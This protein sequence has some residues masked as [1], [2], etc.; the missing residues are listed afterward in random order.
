MPFPILRTPLVVLSESISLLEPNEIVTASFCSSNVTRLLKR[1]FQQKKL[2]EWRLFMTD[3]DSCGT[4]DIE[5][6]K[7]GKKINVISAKHISLLEGQTFMFSSKDP[8]LYFEDLRLGTT[9]IVN[10]VSDLFNLDVFNIVID[11]NGIWAIDWINNRQ[12]KMLGSIV[13]KYLL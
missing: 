6:S 13:Y 8:V 5:T 9:M 11:R 12:E 3:C 4:V 10:Y 1:H 2:L 7:N